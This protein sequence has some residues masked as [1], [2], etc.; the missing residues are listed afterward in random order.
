MIRLDLCH[1]A[2]VDRLASY[3]SESLLLLPPLL[4]LQ[5]I[6]RMM[7]VSLLLLLL[8]VFLFTSRTYRFDASCVLLP[9]LQTH[10]KLCFPLT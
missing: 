8:F 7:L 6:S 2:S 9:S 5:L 1:G 10:E 4:L 3:I